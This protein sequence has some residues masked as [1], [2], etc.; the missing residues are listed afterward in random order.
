MRAVLISAAAVSCFGLGTG[1]LAAQELV[2]PHHLLR[3]K[4]KDASHMVRLL[5]LDLDLAACHASEAGTKE[6]EVIATTADIKRIRAAGLQLSVAIKNLE[7]H[8]ERELAK[9][10]K[11]G[12]GAL[13]LTPALGKGS[14]GGHYTLAEMEAILDAFAKNH[15]KLCSN[16][17][18]IGKSVEGRS[19]WMVKISDNVVVDENEP[20]AFYD[21]MHHAREPVSMETTLLFMDELLTGYGKDP[22]ATFIVNERE[23][24]FVPCV[25]PDGYEYNRRTRPGGGGMWR[26]NRRNN[27]NNVYGVDLNRNYATGWTMPYGGASSNPSSTTYRGTAAFSEPETAAVEAFAKSRSFTQVNSCHTYT[28]VLLRAWGYQQG[29]PSNVAEYKL[30][31][32]LLT[33]ENGIA[34]GSASKLLY[35]ASGT[36]LDHH[37]AA[38][39]AI[40]WTPELGKSSE[41]GFWPNATNL[42]K[43]ARRHQHMFRMMALTTGPYLG[44]ET[45]VVS[46]APGGN[47]NGVV[48]PGETGKV[49]VTVRNQGL[50]ATASAPQVTLTPVTTAISVGVGKVTMAAPGRLATT[51]NASSPL[52]F[53]VPKSFTKPLVELKLVVTGGGQ[54]LQ[55]PVRVLLVPLSVA[56]DHDM[57]QDRGFAR[58]TSTA[59]TGLWERNAPQRT[60]SG[61]Q[62]IQPGNQNT[63]AGRFCW[64]TDSRAGSSAGTYDVDGGY[65][66]L[67][68]PVLDLSHLQ[69]AEVSFHRW[70][71]DSQSDDAF[72]VYVSSD[73][74]TRWT[75][76]LADSRSTSQWTR[77]VHELAGPLTAQMQFRFRAQDLNASLV[78]AGVDDFVIRGVAPNG[79]LTLLSSGKRGTNL[80][81]GI[82]C[83]AGSTVWPIVGKKLAS[84][85]LPG[86]LGTLRVDPNGAVLMKGLQVGSSGYLGVDVPIPQM[87]NLVGIQFH[88]QLLYQAGSAVG[89]GNLQS[90]KGR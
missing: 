43:I 76:I 39:G 83:A 81:M 84:V 73:G 17:V 75:R 37:H 2:P 6:V 10:Y 46:E 28:G 88:L 29:D 3:V 65:T 64:I 16:K 85:Q 24:Y 9:A 1:P 77:F 67:L 40:T 61:S 52:T 57:E 8:Y 42:V 49:V 54:T 35:I 70:Y 41:G 56:V 90:I 27:G 53:S 47:S 23:L 18:P 63:P 34:H 31:G 21:A 86:F 36:A 44:I 74:G 22:E 59:G 60:T 30:L 11:P 80:R 15:P 38:R 68:S 48:E 14:M 7:D 89:F 5:K 58:G 62:T 33:A 66:D 51:S 12:L 26:K 4:V 25:N 69:V 13:G 20:E 45:V 78:E 82:A 71:V 19:I 55:H 50:V 72:E 32:D 87:A 79:T